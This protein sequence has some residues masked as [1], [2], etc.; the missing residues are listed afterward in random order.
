MCWG[1]CLLQKLLTKLLFLRLLPDFL[2]GCR[3]GWIFFVP[4]QAW[5]QS[6]RLISSPPMKPK[7][8]FKCLRCNVIHT[9]DPRNLGRQCYC[10]KPDCKKASKADSQRR[11]AAKPE[12]QNYFRGPEN[13]ER[14][15]QWRKENPGYRRNKKPI[16]ADALQDPLKS[17]P[18]E[19]EVVA[20]KP[21][22]GALQETWFSQPALIVGLI[23]M[24]TGHALQEDIAATTRSVLTRGED[25]LRMT[26][27]S[28]LS[29]TYENQT[30]S[31]P[32][33]AAACAASI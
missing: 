7:S 27:M 21:P 17:Q 31:P 23:S 28:P 33:P 15:R 24:L 9:A 8:K 30:P 18:P 12:N 1:F 6:R 29:Q 14:V 25:I 5:R 3:G 2:R 11:W 4:T 10:N 13:T 20:P 22:P 26:P 16:P 32:R 19:T